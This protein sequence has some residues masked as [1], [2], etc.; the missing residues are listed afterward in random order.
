MYR[1]LT[2]HSSEP[3]TLHIL[4]MD[5]ECRWVVDELSLPHV[6]VTPLDAL[7]KDMFLRKVRDSRT[8]QE[9]CWTLASVFT[10]YILAMNERIEITHLDSKRREFSGGDIESTTYL[11]ADLFFF[12]DPVQVFNQIG[13]RSIAV[14]PHRLIP[15]KNHL[16]VNGK[17]NVGWVTFKNT[18]RGYDCLR[19]WSANCRAKC[20]AS[21]GCG[22]QKY[23]DAWPEKYGDEVCQL[24]IG[25]NVAPWNVSNWEVTEG[26][27][28]DGT[29]I[30][31]Y[32]FHE[33]LEREDGTFRL[34]NYDLRDEDIEF[35]YKPYLKA[36]AEAKQLH[37]QARMKM[38][39][40]RA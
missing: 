25:V 14:T 36:Y 26:P 19:E 24:G 16:E 9:Y 39:Y 32:H 6:T 35:I 34:T 21:D 33:F 27:R 13:T 22:D 5:E 7:E 37:T 3:F 12:S 11:D 1:S 23:I 18:D 20:S 38:E 4:A 29:T 17:F 28:V 10:D 40:E 8:W 15:S 30:V 2:E 31:C